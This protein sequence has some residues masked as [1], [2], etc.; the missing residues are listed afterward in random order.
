MTSPETSRQPTSVN[1]KGQNLTT[2][3]YTTKLETSVTTAIKSNSGETQRG[4]YV[5]NY[6]MSVYDQPEV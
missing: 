1:S 2:V 6:T 5:R 4:Q 3:L